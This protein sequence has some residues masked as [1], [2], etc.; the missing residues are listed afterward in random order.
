MR[1]IRLRTLGIF[2]IAGLAGA[3]LLNT[4]QSVQHAEDKL[5]GLRVSIENE[6]AHIK[7]LKAEWAFLNNPARIEK[8]AVKSLGMTSPEGGTL[9]DRPSDIPRILE[10]PATSDDNKKPYGD[11]VQPIN[12]GGA[13]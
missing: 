9:T 12:A 3:M 7:A 8:L 5:A 1:K 4:S 11:I 10:I 2:G 6:K 13:Q